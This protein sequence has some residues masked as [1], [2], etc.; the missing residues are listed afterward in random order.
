MVI[1]ET[2]KLLYLVIFSALCVSTGYAD[3]NQFFDSKV[4]YF[5]QPKKD[6]Q[7]CKEQQE[8][9]QS[10]AATLDKVKAVSM[11]GQKETGSIELFVDASCQYSDLALKNLSS[12]NKM[13]PDLAIKVSISGSV[14][15]FL[16]IAKSLAQDHPIWDISNDLTGDVAKSSEILKVPAYIFTFQGKTYRIYGEPI[17]EDVW[18]KINAP[19]K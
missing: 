7:N 11:N 19:I 17:I 4:D 3:D 1:L 18:G 6:C 5:E 12:F 8:M 2:K 9:N 16:D 10:V 15:V 13:H 14:S